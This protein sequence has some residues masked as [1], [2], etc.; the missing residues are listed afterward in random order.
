MLDLLWKS[1]SR[2]HLFED[3]TRDEGDPTNG[4][5]IRGIFKVFSFDIHWKERK[6]ERKKERNERKEKK[7]LYT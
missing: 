5:A 7:K 6:K 3:M 2:R 4:G 1:T